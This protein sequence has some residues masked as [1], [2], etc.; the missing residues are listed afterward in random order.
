MIWSALSFLA[1][2]WFVIPG[3]VVG[4]LGAGWASFGRRTKNR[5]AIH[6]LVAAGLGIIV[7]MAIARVLGF[8]LWQELWLQY[9]VGFAAWPFAAS[10]SSCSRSWEAWAR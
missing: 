1:E 2:P 10:S 9:A 8:T 5:A 3:L 7:A 6:G 4:V